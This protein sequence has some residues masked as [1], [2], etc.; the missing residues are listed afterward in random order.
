MQSV[1]AAFTAEGRSTVRNIAESLLVSWKK[2]TTFGN[3]TFTIGV[4]TIGGNDVIGIN[5]GAIGSPGNY[6]YFDETSYAMMVAWERGLS[7]PVGGLAKGFA[8]ALLDNTSDRFTPNYMRGNSELFTSI[9]PR[10]PII[11]S[12][13]FNIGGVD[14]TIPQFSGI[15]DRSPEVNSRSNRTKLHASDYNDFLS[16]RYLDQEV[17]FT[18]KRTDEIMEDRLVAQGLNTAQYELDTGINVIPFGLFKKG[19]RYSDIFHKLAE[20]ENGH[21]YQDEEGI[22]RFENRQ[23]WDSAPYTQV[24]RVI[25]T[26]QVLEAD[27]PDEDHII[28]VVEVKGEEYIKQ[29]LRPLIDYSKSTEIAAN[30]TVE[31]FFDYEVVALEVTAPTAGGTDSYYLANDQPD[32]TGSDVTSSVTV[33]SIDN[34]ATTSKIVFQNNSSSIVYLNHVVVSGRSAVKVGD[35]YARVKDDS[36]VTAYEE[37]VKTIENPFIQNQSWANSLG[38]MLLE[39]HSDPDRLQRIVIKALP[40]LQL[41]DL[42]SWQGLYWRIF[43]IKAFLD[44]DRGFTQELT[45]IQRTIQSYF[46]IGISTIGGSDKIAP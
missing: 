37:R 2:D 42:I 32:D 24:Q 11:I 46:R 10:R 6:R 26:A 8:E 23:H 15:L 3:R 31:L 14:I 22:F 43:G 12:A 45:L 29:P 16:S 35:I 28:N 13:G 4:S 21:F 1:N 7:M 19:T 25:Y 18:S 20:A 44:P 34:F 40:E 9:L 39:D 33:K 41:G 38:Q 27:A 17:I 36:S 5:P 30:G